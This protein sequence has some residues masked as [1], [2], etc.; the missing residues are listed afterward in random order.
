MPYAKQSKAGVVSKPLHL[1]EILVDF[2][3]Y[4]CCGVCYLCARIPIFTFK[5]IPFV[6]DYHVA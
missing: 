4:F 5:Y 2:F 1:A 6:F 3:V